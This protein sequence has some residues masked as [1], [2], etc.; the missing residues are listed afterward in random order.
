MSQQRG[1]Q[2][3]G[4]TLEFAD[5]EIAAVAAGTDQQDGDTDDDGREAFCAVCPKGPCSEESD[6]G[7][8]ELRLLIIRARGKKAGRKISI[9]DVDF[10]GVGARESVLCE[11]TAQQ[12]RERRELQ[13]PDLPVRLGGHDGKKDH[14]HPGEEQADGVGGTVEGLRTRGGEFAR[15]ELSNSAMP[16]S[17][18][19]ARASAPRKRKVHKFQ[20]RLRSACEN[21]QRVLTKREPSRIHASTTAT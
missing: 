5:A 13:T 16:C 7:I 10:G 15:G 8:K 4:D 9:A 21:C 2:R 3:G 6:A 17:E 14:E 12:P 18:R 19:T 11:T 20:M 1:I